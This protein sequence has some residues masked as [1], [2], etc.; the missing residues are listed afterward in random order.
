MPAA[1]WMAR[2]WRLWLPVACGLSLLMLVTGLWDSGSGPPVNPMTT[3]VPSQSTQVV[4]TLDTPMEPGKN[5]VW[6][7]SF[8]AA[9]KELQQSVVAGPVLMEGGNPLAERLN[10]AEDPRNDMA[11][12]L[13][14]TA[15]GWADKGII[16]RIQADVKERFLGA[17]PPSFPGVVPD[18][19]VA[20]AYLEMYL[21][22]PIPYFQNHEPLMFTDG[23]GHRTAI[24]SFGIRS[25]EDHA[26]HELREQVQILYCDA[27]G[28]FEKVEGP[29]FALDLCRSSQPNQMILARIPR[30]PT[31]A[32][33]WADLRARIEQY[34]NEWGASLSRS[35]LSPEDV[36]RR[37]GALADTQIVLVPEMHWRLSH[38]YTEIERKPFT[39][40]SRGTRLDVAQQD[41]QFRLDRSG[42]ELRSEAKMYSAGAGL[43]REFKFD[44]PF[45]ICVRKRGAA[46]PFF[47]V[48]VD[49][50]ALLHAWS[51]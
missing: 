35:N 46:H 10:G 13:C 21:K 37:L 9:W 6:C 23:D 17:L 45:L 41:I 30:K 11:D 12:D 32:D 44:R 25:E 20:Y 48:W 36:E 29:E 18:A 5:V 19:V 28:E 49:N 22:F 42:A 27:T 2:H 33:T 3:L 8:L 38:R 16:E 4:A 1:H 24:R 47:V 39:A 50:V 40:A 7:A 26:Y 34:A 43:I 15:A 14:Y 31:L 51:E